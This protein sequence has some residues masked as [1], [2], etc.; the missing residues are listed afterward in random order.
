MTLPDHLSNFADPWGADA[1]HTLAAP[2]ICI[3]STYKGG[4]YATM[5]GTSMAAPHVSGTV[6]LCIARGSCG[7]LGPAPIISRLRSD[8]SARPSE[9]RLHGRSEL[10]DRTAGSTDTLV[11][12][13]GY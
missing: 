10:A 8:A 12:A 1:A 11:Y 5:S 9:L 4:G 3:Y 2:S 6:A 13:G 7:G